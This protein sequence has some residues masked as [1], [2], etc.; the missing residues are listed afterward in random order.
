MQ[1]CLANVLN[2]MAEQTIGQPPLLLLSAPYPELPL[3]TPNALLGWLV[4]MPPT[5]PACAPAVPGRV[6]RCGAAFGGQ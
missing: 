4:W 1:W 5:L 3:T 6:A 2:R